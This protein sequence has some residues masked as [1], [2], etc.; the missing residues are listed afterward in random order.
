[1]KGVATQA[2]RTK[3]GIEEEE[4]MVEADMVVDK[5]EVV[6][7]TERIIITTIII[8]QKRMVILILYATFLLLERSIRG[9]AIS[10]PL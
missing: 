6:G 5:A 3:R 8:I 7:I 4:A 10:V 9:S 1:M 2:M